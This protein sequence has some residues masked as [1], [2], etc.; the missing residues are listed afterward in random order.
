VRQIGAGLLP[1]WRWT[2]LHA[3]TSSQ[4]SLDVVKTLVDAG[5]E[6]NVQDNEGNTPLHFAVKRINREKLPIRDYEGIIRL[7]LERKADVHIVNIGGATP[8]HTAA[9][10]RANPSAVEMLIQAGADV[11][12]RT[13]KSYGAWTPLHGA[14]ARNDAAVATVLLKYGA[15]IYVIDGRELTPLLVAERGGF[16]KTANVLHAYARAQAENSDWVPFPFVYVPPAAGLPASIGGVV[17]GR[18][19][20]N[21]Q[22]VAGA[23][24]YLVD[25]PRV[26]SGRYGTATTDDQ[27]RFSMTGVPPGH[28]YVGVNGS[29]RVSR[30]AGGDLFVTSEG[31]TMTLRPFNQEF[32]VCKLFDLGTP[33]PNESVGSRPVLRWDAYPDAKRYVVN[34]FDRTSSVALQWIVDANVTSVQVDT[35][36][37]PG[38][39]EWRVDVT[40]ARGN[41]IGCSIAPRGFTVRP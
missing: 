14:V 15:R 21:G 34:V 8:L 38:S 17:Q 6:I 9:A 12:L 35:D 19:L 2:L 10:F 36:L 25:V 20:W 11:N 32:H 13:F 1:H 27:G 22:P 39:Y 33:A 24:V 16:A 30:I 31:S 26:G 23:S 41:T 40:A 29:H 5:A 7:L 37:P 3:A 18:L 4:A 28:K